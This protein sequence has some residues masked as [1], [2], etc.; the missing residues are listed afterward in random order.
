MAHQQRPKPDF[1]HQED[2][3]LGHILSELYGSV[4]TKKGELYSKSG[5]I[6]LRGGL[7]R[8]LNN[9]PF[10]RNINI[11]RDRLFNN[12]N[13]VF[14]GMIKKLRSEGLDT[15]EHKSPISPGD[16]DKLY[17]TGTIG[18]DSPIP[19]QRK[20]CFDIGVNFARRGRESLRELKKANLS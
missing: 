8:H 10:S 4:R 2:V 1:E 12:A 15:T 7:N 3:E 5:Y 9:P 6:N 19:L 11:M 20:V 14:Y 17:S 18:I 16:I 13:T